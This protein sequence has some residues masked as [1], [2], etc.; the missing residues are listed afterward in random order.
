MKP[1]AFKDEKTIR[2]E[3]GTTLGIKN[4]MAVPRLDKIVINCGL[5]EAT[6]DK[7]VIEKM[8][9]QLLVITGQ[10]PVIT[11]AKKA[12]S[13]YKTREGDPIGLKIT[14]RKKRMWDFLKRLIGI[15]LPR[16]RDFRGIANN[17]FDGKGKYTL[18][19]KEQTMFP[20][21]EYA[22]VDKVRGFSATFVTTAKN[23]NDGK[24]LLVE[25]GLPFEK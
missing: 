3:L 18:G 8:E 7:K 22:M 19:I 9:S 23:D 2:K 25:L 17:G 5:G 6:K 12:I 16:V 24:A 21:L 20:E 11:R 4:P 15:A 1:T 10:K 14:L 13:S